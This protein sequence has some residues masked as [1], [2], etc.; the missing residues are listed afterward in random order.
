MS[1]QNWTREQKLAALTRLPWTIST[2]RE[3]DGTWIARVAEMSDAIATGKSER[4]LAADL[5]ESVYASLA[6]RLD[7]GDPIPLPSGCDLP[8]MVSTLLS[9]RYKGT[10]EFFR[11]LPPQPMAEATAPVAAARN[12]VLQPA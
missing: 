5:W 8:W 4:E 7:R 12:F 6:V 11:G 3:N 10:I 9:P 1:E 2:E